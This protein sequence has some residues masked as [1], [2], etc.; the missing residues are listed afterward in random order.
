[1]NKLDCTITATRSQAREDFLLKDLE[2]YTT[3]SSWDWAADSRFA[4]EFSDNETQTIILEAME[5]GAPS[6]FRI[7]AWL[8]WWKNKVTNKRMR[9]LNAM[10]KKG[11]VRSFWIGTGPGGK[12]MFGV[13][14][15][16]GY[17][18]NTD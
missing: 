10:Q 9:A 1:M 11:L 14:R 13:G 12:G 18:L 17:L 7:D 4:K 6:S 15:T 16:K 5:S 8:S 3:Q 2:Q